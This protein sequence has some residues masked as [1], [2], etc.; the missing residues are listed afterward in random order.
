EVPRRVHECVHGVGLAARRSAAH[1]TDR[2]HKARTAGQ[3]VALSFGRG[4]ELHVL[5]QQDW[6]LIFGHGDHAIGRAVHD[7]NRRAPVAL[8]R[9]QPVAHAVV[10]TPS[11]YT[12]LLEPVGYALPCLLVRQTVE[13]ARVNHDPRFDV[14][15]IDWQLVGGDVVRSLGRPHDDANGQVE[16]AGKLPVALTG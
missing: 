13:L 14:G 12:A 15:R 11:A 2:V 9:Y 5:R 1:G 16:L 8:P 7:R 4:L 6:Q 10:H 3:R